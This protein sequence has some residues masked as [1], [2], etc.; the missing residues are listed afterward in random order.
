VSKIFDAQFY[1]TQYGSQ[2]A[3]P[4]HLA[5]M[6]WN[7]SDA[8]VGVTKEKMTT[9][10]SDYLEAKHFQDSNEFLASEARKTGH[11]EIC[12]IPTSSN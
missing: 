5:R 2:K 7:G 6:H 12:W 11:T 4:E 1:I 8:P 10:A 9:T 3:G